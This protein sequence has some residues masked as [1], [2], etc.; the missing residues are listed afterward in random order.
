MT[1]G[2]AAVSRKNHDSRL[3]AT[4]N[5][6]AF[7]LA[8]ALCMLLG[9][10]NAQASRCMP[11]SFEGDW[12]VVGG[13]P[14]Y[15]GLQNAYYFGALRLGMRCVDAGTTTCRGEGDERVCSSTSAVRAIYTISVG[16][17]LPSFDGPAELA[18]WPATDATDSTN[19]FRY[20]E[21]II[22]GNF[23]RTWFRVQADGNLQVG[24]EVTIND[25][26]QP[27]EW[28]TFSRPRPQ[29]TPIKPIRPFPII[30]G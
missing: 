28:R 4:L 10:S 16:E 19:G 8:A 29:L 30:R 24:F 22:N 3:V 26:K 6:L 27:V 11:P 20:A 21:A 23:T 5:K 13:S 18:Y 17:S 7:A 14:A 12:L 1:N 25:V 15:R 2:C 9:V